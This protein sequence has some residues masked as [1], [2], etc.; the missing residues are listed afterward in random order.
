MSTKKIILDVAEKLF[1]QFGYNSIG[2]DLIRD[3]ADVS[4]TSIYRHFGSKNKLIEAVLNRRHQRFIAELRD[5]ITTADKTESKLEE[6]LKWHLA[7]FKE[8][9]FKGCMFMHAQAEF[10]DTDA[11]ISEEAKLHKTAI[12]SLL[13][14]ILS[15][16]NKITQNDIEYQSEILMTFFEGLI[17]RAEFED[18]S[19]FESIYLN[20]MKTLVFQ[21]S[22]T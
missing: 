20:L 21:G 6:M 2:V 19:K 3:E 13:I 1:N 16:D 11:R 5:T 9:S 22:N 10:K 12:K 17:I 18:I 7:W 14:E 8:D 15:S 4:K